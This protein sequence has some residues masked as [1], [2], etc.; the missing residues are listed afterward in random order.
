M[1]NEEYAVIKTTSN[2]GPSYIVLR[3][4]HNLGWTQPLMLLDNSQWL[5]TSLKTRLSAN[6][7]VITILWL[8]IVSKSYGI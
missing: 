5:S 1:M 8:D 3:C 2:E 4:L 7:N 6:Q